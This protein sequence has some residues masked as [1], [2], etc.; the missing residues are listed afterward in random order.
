MT[1]ESPPQLFI[2]FKFGEFLRNGGRFHQFHLELIRRP[3]ESR[4]RSI[5]FQGRKTAFLF[6][7]LASYFVHAFDHI[8]SEFLLFIR[9]HGNQPVV[10]HIDSSNEW[11]GNEDNNNRKNLFQWCAVFYLAIDD[12]GIT[13]LQLYPLWPFSM[14]CGISVRQI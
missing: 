14:L 5:I 4:P 11:K 13:S 2:N 12:P 10:L 9:K 6:H 7:Q 1:I 3:G 8:T